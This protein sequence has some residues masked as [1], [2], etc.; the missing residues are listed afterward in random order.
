MTEERRRRGGRRRG[1]KGVDTDWTMSYV[2]VPHHTQ[3]SLCNRS[4]YCPHLS[5]TVHM[6]L[7]LPVPNLMGD[8]SGILKVWRKC[9][10]R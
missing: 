10:G 6:V 3:R 7:R 5:E 4:R 8:A 1:G 9:E 2:L